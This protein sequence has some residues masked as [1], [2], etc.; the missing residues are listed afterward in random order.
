MQS[1]LAFPDTH[2]GRRVGAGRKPKREAERVGVP[3]RQRSDVRSYYPMLVTIR[4]APLLPSLRAQVEIASLV[5]KAIEDSAVRG[6]F[7]ILEYT[8]QSNHLH[9][10]IEADDASKLALLLL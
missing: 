10:I 8:V 4:C 3:H 1:K 6:G 2:G 5:M 7:R 9:L